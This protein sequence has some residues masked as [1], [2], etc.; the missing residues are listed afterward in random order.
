MRI[1]RAVAK[2]ALSG[3]LL[4]SGM[5]AGAADPPTTIGP[6]RSA[7]LE[8]IV[9]RVLVHSGIAAMRLS[10]D[11][12]QV[13]M[14]TWTASARSAYLSHSEAPHTNTL[15]VMDVATQKVTPIVVPTRDV[16]SGELQQAWGFFWMSNDRLAVNIGSQCYIY[17]LD[18]QRERVLSRAAFHVGPGT[19]GRDPF[20]IVAGHDLFAP[21][22]I[23]RINL[24]TGAET[25]VSV[26]LP[27]KV[28]RA[29]WDSQGRLRAAETIE[30]TWYKHGAR[31]TSWYRHD[32][33]SPWK[34][35]LETEVI[36]DRW[37]IV[38]A[39]D[40]S[41]QVLIRSREERDTWAVFGYDVSTGKKTDLEVSH[42]G[43]DVAAFEEEDHADLLRVVTSGLKPSTIWFDEPWQKVQAAVDAALPGA[44]N[45][46]SGK[47]NGMVMI[48]SYSD[49]DPGRWLLLDRPRMKMRPLG[50]RLLKF[51][52]QATRAMETTTYTS[53][54]GLAIPAYLT[55]PADAAGPRPMVVYIHGGPV[56]RDHWG[57]NAEVQILA[58]A[59]YAVFQPQFR[60]S[61][62]FGHKFEVAGYRQWGL[63]MQDD[64]TAGVKEMIRRGVADP[65]RICI[66]GASY[67]GYAALWGLAKTPDLYRCGASF[68]GPS[69]I[70]ERFTDWSDTNLSKV[71]PDF[72]RFYIGDVDTMK[73][74]FDAVSPQKHA[75]RIRVPVLLAHGEDDFRV[76]I[77]HSERMAKA[78]EAAHNPA[79]VHW[80]PHEG[81]GFAYMGDQRDFQLA[82]LKFLDR[83][84]G[85]SS[86]LAGQWEP[87][88]GAPAAAG[89][90]ATAPAH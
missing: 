23:R 22:S 90:S 42:P 4:A 21:N 82:L 36:E 56:E 53:F 77:G 32:D 80:Y 9:D 6:E 88:A 13:G 7:A 3:V 48:Y 76:P 81:H 43:V 2:F 34:K 85:P 86:A 68:A 75:D 16:G 33:D 47:P 20:A 17:T 55:R 10:P 63:N 19:A 1:V 45:E 89:A 11:G 67:G 70:A 58:A 57:F 79:E 29:V 49:H 12:N 28:V 38:A 15:L 52:T 39:P 50:S 18:G 65:Q 14:L 31:V 84:I 78:L 26:G 51:D 72:M 54:D 41:D 46:L 8:A 83:N 44:I 24:R 30:T 61:S 59:G 66:Y 27:D 37:H 60:G 62:G 74:D 71:G 73:A 64:I 69:D 87:I 35:V 25:S 40:D 5:Q